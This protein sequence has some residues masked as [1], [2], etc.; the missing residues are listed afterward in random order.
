MP[1]AGQTELSY[2]FRKPRSQQLRVGL[3]PDA[4]VLVAVD[5]GAEACGVALNRPGLDNVKFLSHAR[6]IIVRYA[7]GSQGAGFRVGKADIDRLGPDNVGDED[8]INDQRERGTPGRRIPPE[9]A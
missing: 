5:L 3:L 8:R 4:D 9:S 7:L 2:K 1:W 6:D